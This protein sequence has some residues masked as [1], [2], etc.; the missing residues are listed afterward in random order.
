MRGLSDVSETG[1][2]WDGARIWLG[3]ELGARVASALVLAIV[4]LLATYRGGWPFT[5][6]WLAAGIVMAVEWVNMTGIQPSRRIKLQLGLCLAFVTL[7]YLLQGIGPGA[8]LLIPAGLV[9]GS[10]TAVLGL[11]H[12]IRDWGWA[13]GGLWYAAVIVLVP[14]VVRDHPELGI[15]GLLWMFAV[16]WTTDI[17]AYFTG[18][19]FG[20]AKLWSRVSPKKTW[21]GFLGG[22]VAGGCA[23]VL[24]FLIAA[25]QGWTPVAPLW[26]V[27]IVSVAG[28]VV[29]QLGDLGES[30]LKRRFGAKDSG[31]LI[32]GHG[33]VMDRLDGFWAVALL[34]GGI[35][36]GVFA[37][38]G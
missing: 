28:S 10:V 27:A 21:S 26:L 13:V 34:M 11:T 35:M 29:S 14:P 1:A 36:A 24:A 5:L 2:P 4:A 32:P 6:F 37:V 19:R 38:R 3:S 20:G 23:G 30:A 7:A 8:G 17:A 31:Q 25:T 22:L 18:R 15:T 33:G 16:V 9:V 12:T